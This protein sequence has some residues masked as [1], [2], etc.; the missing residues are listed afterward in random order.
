[1]R[2]GFSIATVF[3]L[4][5]MLCASFVSAGWFGDLFSGKLTGHVTSD[6]VDNDCVQDCLD[7]NCEVYQKKFMKAWCMNKF[8]ADCESQCSGNNE[9]IGGPTGE[10]FN[11]G[12]FVQE[13]CTDSDGGLNYYEVGRV[14]DQYGSDYTDFCMD[15][16]GYNVPEA[17][18]LREHYCGLSSFL[19]SYYNCSDEG[20]ICQNGACV[21][22]NFTNSTVECYS[23]DG[24]FPAHCSPEGLCVECVTTQHCY[25]YNMSNYHCYDYGCVRAGYPCDSNDDCDAG[26]VCESGECV[27]DSSNLERFKYEGASNE[28]TLNEGIYD[29]VPRAVVN[30]DMP[31]LLRD[32]LY[33]DAE[34]NSFDYS[35]R[36]IH[37]NLMFQNFSDS[38]YNYGEWTLG[39]EIQERGS[40]LNY[41]LG[42]VNFPYYQTLEGSEIQILGEDYFVGDADFYFDQI[43]KINLFGPFVS[44]AVSEGMSSFVDF[45][46]ISHEVSLDYVTNSEAR[47][48]VDGEVMRVL[49]VGQSARTSSG[50]Y[51]LLEEINMTAEMSAEF[52]IGRGTWQ[53]RD[54][55]AIEI[56]DEYVYDLTG[57]IETTAQG[58]LSSITF[59]W[60]ADDDE[61]IT[62]VQ[63]LYFPEFESFYFELESINYSARPISADFYLVKT[64]SLEEDISSE[65]QPESQEA[66]IWKIRNVFR[67]IFGGRR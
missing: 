1:M 25:D 14:V 60:R 53:I 46:G 12:S 27:V 22:N 38:D 51:I 45:E 44:S 13:N 9:V 10:V 40:I 64:E 43:V 18:T 31:T 41:T 67:N 20:M 55:R 7:S 26:E 5:M 23:D 57:F 24:C 59:E 39:F 32:N 54:D 52:L 19:Y 34:G 29:V 56:N 16:N 4:S 37:S 48:I 61:F 49:S 11:N 36:I 50:D 65:N 35:Q 33:F 2:R 3:V 28:L 63:D 62:E 6:S 15:E 66:V 47:F 21:E 8:Q 30:E 17:I 42:F 58:N